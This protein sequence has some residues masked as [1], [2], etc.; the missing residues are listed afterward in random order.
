MDF[1]IKP[2]AQLAVDS[3]HLKEAI[4]KFEE[5]DY[6]AKRVDSQAA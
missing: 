1:F 5:A 2:Y 3:P 6:T 4:R